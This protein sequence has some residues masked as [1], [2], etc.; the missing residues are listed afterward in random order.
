M[1]AAV[2]VHPEIHIGGVRY[3][4]SDLVYGSGMQKK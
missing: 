2:E 4:D 1:A 3:L